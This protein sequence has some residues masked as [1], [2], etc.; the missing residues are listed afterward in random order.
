M[1][2][3][4]MLFWLLDSFHMCIGLCP[5]VYWS[6]STN[7]Q[8]RPSRY[9]SCVYTHTYWYRFCAQCSHG[10]AT[11]SRIDEIIG[12]FCRKA[13][14]LWGSFAQ[15]TCNFIDLTN[16]S[17]PIMYGMILLLPYTFTLTL[18]H[19]ITYTVS[20]TKP[21]SLNTETSSRNNDTDVPCC[22]PPSMGTYASTVASASTS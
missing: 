20:R 3:R 18:T 15:E 1:C 10:V 21:N 19:A 14:L 8:K 11:V 22:L 12:L 7:S 4:A 16:W 2:L 9:R 17:H 6:L 5:H 13:F